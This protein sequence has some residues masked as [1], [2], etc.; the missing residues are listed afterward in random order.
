MKSVLRCLRR[1]LLQYFK[2]QQWIVL[3]RISASLEA[4]EITSRNLIS[5]QTE[6]FVCMPFINTKMRTIANCFGEFMSEF[7]GK[8]KCS[9]LFLSAYQTN[10][11]IDRLL[12]C[13]FFRHQSAEQ[14][15][16]N[17]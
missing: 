1:N 3:R 6:F 16:R 9:I 11:R 5:C 12:S 14:C 8:N 7:W 10:Q 2:R 15:C 4:G 17:V 13:P